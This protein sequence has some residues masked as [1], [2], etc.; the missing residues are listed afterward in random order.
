VKFQI[1]AAMTM[2]I[3][4][5]W[6]V[7]PCSLVQLYKRSY[8]FITLYSIVSWYSFLVGTKLLILYVFGWPMTHFIWNWPDISMIKLRCV[9]GC[10][11]IY[12]T[13]VFNSRTGKMKK[14]QYEWECKVFFTLSWPMFYRFT[15]LWL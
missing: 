12:I 6:N 3:I 8:I 2:K 15:K 13:S 5:I 9:S 10:N 11:V 14:W 4:V 7:T 1:S